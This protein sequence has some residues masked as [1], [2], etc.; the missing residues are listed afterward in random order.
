MGKGRQESGASRV[1]AGDVINGEASGQRQ[2]SQASGWGAAAGTSAEEEAGRRA[3]RPCLCPHGAIFCRGV[4][5][6]AKLRGEATTQK[7]GRGRRLGFSVD[8]P[9]W[10]PLSALCQRALRSGKHPQSLQVG[11]ASRL[12]RKAYWRH[13]CEAKICHC[14]VREL[15]TSKTKSHPVASASC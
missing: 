2:I 15:Y 12:L 11:S 10:D 5:Q 13:W 3:R 14:N 1:G 9:G 4:A 7:M 6:Q 8:Q